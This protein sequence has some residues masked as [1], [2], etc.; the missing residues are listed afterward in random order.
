MSPLRRVILF[1]RKILPSRPGPID[2]SRRTRRAVLYIIV[3][4]AARNVLLLIS[5]VII[6]IINEYVKYINLHLIII[7]ITIRE[8]IRILSQA[9]M[10]YYYY[11]L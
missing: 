3:R 6:V 7:V 8:C 2:S 11:I 1:C 10:Y 5:I 9:Q 4:D